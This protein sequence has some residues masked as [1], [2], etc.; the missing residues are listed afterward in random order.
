MSSSTSTGT[1]VEA[2]ASPFAIMG[3]LSDW[4]TS[5]TYFSPR[6]LFMRMAAFTSRRMPASVLRRSLTRALSWATERDSTEPTFTPAIRTAPSLT[7]PAALSNLA[8]TMI[9]LPSLRP[10]TATDM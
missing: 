2:M 7:R 1:S 6:R 4:G 10:P 9:A 5:S 8:V 3:A